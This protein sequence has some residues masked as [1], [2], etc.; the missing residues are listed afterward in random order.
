M[1]TKTILFLGASRG[2]GF[3]AALSLLSSPQPPTCIFLLRKPDAL[4]D[5]DEVKALSEPA[6][7]AIRIVKGDATVKGDVQ[8]AVDEAQ[9]KLDSVVFSVGGSYLCPQDSAGRLLIPL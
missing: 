2:C 1:A 9:G 7:K 8:K 6:L 4:L 3:Y 5:S